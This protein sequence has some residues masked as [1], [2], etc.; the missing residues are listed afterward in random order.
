MNT[1]ETS[2]LIQADAETQKKAAETPPPQMIP[3]A[4]QRRVTPWANSEP[5]PQQIDHPNDVQ[6]AINFYGHAAKS[7]DDHLAAQVAG[8]V[9]LITDD[10]SGLHD[11]H[12]SRLKSLQK[13]GFEPDHSQK[14]ADFMLFNS[15]IEPPTL[16]SLVGADSA[17][18]LTGM[19]DRVMQT[20]PVHM[21]LPLYTQVTQTNENGSGRGVTA[22]IL[23]AGG[24]FTDAVNQGFGK[25][26]SKNMAVGYGVLAGFVQASHWNMLSSEAKSTLL[27]MPTDGFDNFVR[28]TAKRSGMELSDSE[29]S[30]TTDALLDTLESWK[31]PNFQA[32]IGAGLQ[33]NQQAKK[34][35]LDKENED[36]PNTSSVK[37]TI[38]SLREFS[39][40]VPV[41]EK[42]NDS[43]NK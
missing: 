31:K 43:N 26:E 37:A 10:H 35:L 19:N 25:D 3:D 29:I 33:W 16:P 27:K 21:T 2:A 30:S 41:K 36:R 23:N 28:V 4:L 14:V 17:R 11:F 40:T 5:G 15:E 39:N 6:N 22:A 42:P 38:D 34:Y 13:Q 1:E 7:T 32:P 18:D 12:S 24:M 20:S 8:A 9:A